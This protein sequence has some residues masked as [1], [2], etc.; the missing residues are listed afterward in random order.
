[1]FFGSALLLV[2]I[3]KFSVPLLAVLP[4]KAVASSTYTIIILL[5]LVL[6]AGLVGV[7]GPTI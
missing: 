1:L 7:L 6:L 5:G 3:A 2:L 4:T